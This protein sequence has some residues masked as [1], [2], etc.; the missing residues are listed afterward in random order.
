METLCHEDREAYL[1]LMTEKLG[2]R[3][4]F[5]DTVAEAIGNAEG[6]EDLTQYIA[7]SLIESANDSDL[8]VID[9]AGIGRRVVATVLEYASASISDDDIRERATALIM[10]RIN[11]AQTRAYWAGSSAR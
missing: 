2:R 8:R 4:R 11:D 6:C 10:L 1:Q 9:E 5:D 3:D 7:D